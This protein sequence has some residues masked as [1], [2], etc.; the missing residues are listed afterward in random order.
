[1][2][3]NH[4]GFEKILWEAADKF[5]ANSKLKPLEYSVPVLGLIFLLYTYFR[6][7][8]AEKE[9]QQK[10]VGSR[11]SLTK[12]DYQAWGVLYVPEQAR[13]RNL[14]NLPE[15]ENIGQAINEAMKAIEAENE[16]L[17]DALPKI[18]NRLDN[19]RNL[20]LPPALSRANWRFS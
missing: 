10:A 18:Y 16:D 20:L 9:L 12:A 15:G 19:D 14:L 17:K 13:Y 7:A 3:N 1:M 5:R 8:Q 11:R 4:N 2:P 6:F